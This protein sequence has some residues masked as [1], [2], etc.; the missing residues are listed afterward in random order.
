MPVQ[1]IEERT[2]AAQIEDAATVTEAL[3]REYFGPAAYLR[4]GI[5]ENPETGAEQPA[6]EV[7]YCFDDWET[8]FEHLECLHNAFMDAYV[9]MV[10]PGLRSRIALSP[11]PTDAD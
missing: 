7:H 5:H 11:I 4:R 6:F 10:A 2:L 3:A 8:A 9:R 1:T